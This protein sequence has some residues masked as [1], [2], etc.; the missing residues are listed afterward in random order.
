MNGLFLATNTGSQIGSKT[1]DLSAV[2]PRQLAERY[3]GPST[4][5]LS[6]QTRAHLKTDQAFD[7]VQVAQCAMGVIKFGFKSFNTVAGE[8]LRGLTGLRQL[9]TQGQ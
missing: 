1:C 9:L 7:A 4:D 2:F 8:P 6:N 5:D 3:T